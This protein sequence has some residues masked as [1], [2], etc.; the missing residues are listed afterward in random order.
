[1]IESAR[2]WLGRLDDHH[3]LALA[4][5]LV[6]AALVRLMIASQGPIPQ[7]V[8]PQDAVRYELAAQRILDG[9]TYRFPLGADLAEGPGAYEAYL[10]RP[11]NAHVMPGYPYVVAAVWAVAGPGE[12]GRVALI[13]LQNLLGLLAVA[14]TYTL[15]RRLGSGAT[16]VLAAAFTGLYLPLA[17]IDNAVMTESLFTALLLVLVLAIID[18]FESGGVWRA[19]AAGVVLA[20]CAY[21][22][23][24][25]VLWPA[26]AWIIAWLWWSRR[27][28]LAQATLRSVRGAVMQ[29][30]V[31]LGALAPWVARNAAIY[32]EFVPLTTAGGIP[33]LEFSLAKLGREL[34]EWLTL[35]QGMTDLEIGRAA[36]ELHRELLDSASAS[37]IARI[38]ALRVW[39]GIWSLFRPY[40]FGGHYTGITTLQGWFAAPWLLLPH[41]GLVLGAVVGVWANR[42]SLAHLVVGSVPAYFLVLHT[43]TYPSSRYM[44]PAMALACVLAA[45]ALTG[46]LAEKESPSAAE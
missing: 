34:P 1:M 15:G 40:D 41:L 26:V 8:G 7:G 5:V 33:G 17:W 2:R 30:F 25:V 13:A 19:I 10:K 42:R 14:L 9:A 32:R 43:L 22:R 35:G 23:P 20:A 18:L 3:R 31:S 21:V 24:T 29:A 37:E 44:L 16:G 39:D 27:D 11:A 46:A 12:S 38:N 28:G 6:V 4:V 36:S 45:S